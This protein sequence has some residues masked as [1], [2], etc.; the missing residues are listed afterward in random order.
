MTKNNCS[1]NELIVLKQKLKYLSYIY[2]FS[3]LYKKFMLRK[4]I[5]AEDARLPPRGKQ[6]PGAKRNGQ[7]LYR[8]LYLKLILLFLEVAQSQWERPHRRSRGGSAPTPRKAS[9]LQRKST[10]TFLSE[11]ATIPTKIAF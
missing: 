7:V 8:S 11:I 5:E 4:L 2:L 9:I 10:T 1:K 6:V 3:F